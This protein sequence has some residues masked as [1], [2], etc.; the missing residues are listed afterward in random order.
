M[1]RITMKTSLR[2]RSTA[3]RILAPGAAW[4]TGFIILAALGAL[5][6]WAIA[7]PVL[8]APLTVAFGPDP[9]QVVTPGAVAATAAGAGLLGWGLLAALSRAFT[10]GPGL[11]KVVAFAVLFLSL[12]GPLAAGTTTGVKGA[13][14][15]MHL[16][17]AVVLI[18]GL[19]KCTAPGNTGGTIARR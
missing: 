11:W 12:T 17:V 8:G 13:L 5:A 9:A 1:N 18:I 7:V 6:V 19:P 15:L 3:T 14:V 2:Q 4:G 10:K 16:V